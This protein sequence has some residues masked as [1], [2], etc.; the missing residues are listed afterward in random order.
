[1]EISVAKKQSKF[2]AFCSTDDFKKSVKN[3]VNDELFW[4]GI[5]QQLS[6]ENLIKEA[7]DNKL[8]SQEKAIKDKVKILVCEKLREYAQ[9]E[10][11]TNVAKELTIQITNYLNSHHQMQQMLTYHI[12]QLDLK[13]TDTA[14]QTLTK[15]A[16]ED[17]YNLVTKIYLEA[18]QQKGDLKL[19]EMQSDFN[20]QLSENN[21]LF[22]N[23]LT[24]LRK[25]NNKELSDLKD[26]LVKL[27]NVEKTLSKHRQTILDQDRKIIVLQTEIS[28]LQ[29][30]FGIGCIMFTGAIYYL[31]KLRHSHYY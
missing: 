15:L 13:L 21:R 18:I 24:E 19:M 12:Q 27:D 11:P 3:A 7:I 26:G 8:L 23:Q 6:I 20:Q 5:I 16:N 14:T 4:R 1:M 28:N 22:T 17:Q 31:D 29:C 9:N 10:I 2:I 30:L 25:T